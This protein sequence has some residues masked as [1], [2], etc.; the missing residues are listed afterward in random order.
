MCIVF[1]RFDNK[2]TGETMKENNTYPDYYPNNCPLDDSK[3][4]DGTF[5][6]FINPDEID[7]SLK[8]DIILNPGKNYDNE[9]DACLACGLS[10]NPD[11]ENLVKK[12]GKY[13]YFRRCRIAK[14]TL[15][16]KKGRIKKSPSACDP[17]HHTWW[18][19]NDYDP[20]SDLEYVD[21]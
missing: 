20:S 21:E 14:W 2:I 9:S 18:V 17:S 16:S 12:R 4:A 10:V 5:Y 8:P 15:S 11:I 1:E 7:V 3:P 6:R 13:K 19:P